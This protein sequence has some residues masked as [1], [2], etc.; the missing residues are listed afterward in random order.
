MKQEGLMYF[1]DTHLT[2]LALCIFFGYFLMVLF[3]ALKSSKKEIAHLESLPFHEG[4]SS[5]PNLTN[6]ESYGR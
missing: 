3:R 6:G 1:T 2:V 4:N 5:T